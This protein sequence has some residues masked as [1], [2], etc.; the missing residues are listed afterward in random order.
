MIQPRHGLLVLVAGAAVDSTSGL[1]SRIVPADAFTTASGR[2]LFAF[3]VLALAVLWRDRGRIG[4]F[5][6]VGL[7][8]IAFIGLNALGMSFNILSLKYTAVANFFMIFATAPFAAAVAARL[9]LGER[10]DG[11]TMAAALAGLA[12]VTIMVVGSARGDGLVG[13]LLAVACVGTYAGLVLLVRRLPHL[14]LL[15][16]IALTTLTAGLITLPFADYGAV[17]AGGLAGLAVFGAVQLALGNILIFNAAKHIPA[18][19]SGLLG[20]LNAAFAPLWVGLVLGEVPPP[21][22][23]AGGALILA[24]AAAHLA[25]SIRSARRPVPA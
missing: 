18:A 12:G 6:S 1:F 10:L 4:A 3:L 24:A 7:G 17:S 8:G 15:P 2:S 16:V 9:I 11:P 19:Q 23:I 20:I 5:L 22:T 14:D 21:A 13:D 25:W